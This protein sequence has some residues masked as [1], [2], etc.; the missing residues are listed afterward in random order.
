MNVTARG[1]EYTTTLKRHKF[2]EGSLGCVCTK[3]IT[4][5]KRNQ[6]EMEYPMQVVTA[7]GIVR[8]S[9][10]WLLLVRTP[11]RGWEPPGGIVENGE[12]LL[13]AL[14]REV[15]EE[16]GIIIRVGRLKGICTELSFPMRLT[17]TFEGV[18]VGGELRTSPESLEVGWF[19]PEEALQKVSYPTQHERLH[20]ILPNEGG[21]LYRIYQIDPY[22]LLET[23]R[24]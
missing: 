3:N 6:S 20:D 15:F 22:N 16:S 4:L 21:I 23:V 24:L 1:V 13:T 10:G 8:D 17:F 7:M 18:P 19:S 5:E 12:G 2:L 9:R 11:L 14:E